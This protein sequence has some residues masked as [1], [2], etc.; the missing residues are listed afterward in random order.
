MTT[1]R[2]TLMTALALA[3]AAPLA[4]QA[5][6]RYSW[7]ERGPRPIDSKRVLLIGLDPAVVDYSALPVDMNAEKLAA[8]LADQAEQLKQAGYDAQWCFI[9]TS[10]DAERKPIEVMKASRF[11]AVLIGAGVR[12]LPAHFLLFERL[13]NAVHQHAFGARICFNE[14]AGSTLQAVKRW[15]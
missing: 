1:N 10:A 6:G 13:M 4:A 12:A 2:R 7:V 15:V 8:M 5:Q 3:G 11:G 9:D 14:D